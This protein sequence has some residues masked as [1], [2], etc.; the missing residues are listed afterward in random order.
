[1]EREEEKKNWRERKEKNRVRGKRGK[2]RYQK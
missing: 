1:M 2:K